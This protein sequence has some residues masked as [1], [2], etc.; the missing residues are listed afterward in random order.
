MAHLHLWF[1][2]AEQIS[3]E[4]SIFSHPLLGEE[5]KALRGKSAGAYSGYLTFQWSPAVHALAILAVRA[6][7]RAEAETDSG[8][9][10]LHILEGEFRSAAASLDY[11]L[12]KT[13]LWL[14]DMFGIDKSGM[15]LSKRIFNRSNPER[16]RP[17]PVAI[18][19]NENFLKYRDIKIHVNGS[20]LSGANLRELASR[21]EREFTAARSEIPEKPRLVKTSSAKSGTKG[22]RSS[23]HSHLACPCCGAAFRL[24]FE[25]DSDE[26]QN[27]L[28]L[29]KANGTR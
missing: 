29:K 19:I 2:A 3:L 12:G 18:S 28:V 21:L 7:A 9:D 8:H 14:L 26:S 15:A 27:D 4:K 6:A 23:R 25:A 16:K 11:C 1:S 13:P 5:R 20:V 22:T 10:N 24:K 17:G